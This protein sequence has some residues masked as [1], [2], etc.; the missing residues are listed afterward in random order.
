MPLGLEIAG[1]E[2]AEDR[3]RDRPA[4]DGLMRSSF[5]SRDTHR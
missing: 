1:V 4:L 2:D 3:N 5:F